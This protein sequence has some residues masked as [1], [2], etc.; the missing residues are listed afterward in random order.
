MS[1]GKPHANLTAVLQSFNQYGG[2]YN[3]GGSAEFAQSLHH[4]YVR[5]GVFPGFVPPNDRVDSESMVETKPDDSSVVTGFPV[6]EFTCTLLAEH[7]VA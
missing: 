6:D 7:F 5:G 1:R 2:A 3:L 4:P